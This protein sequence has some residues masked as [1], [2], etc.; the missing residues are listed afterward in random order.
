M[1]IQIVIYSSILF[2]LSEFAL[3]IAKRS[4]K[5]GSKTRNDKSSLL[6]LWLAIPL[7]LTAGFFNAN[8]QLWDVY[9]QTIAIVGLSVLVI[10]ISIR[11]ISIIQLNKGFTVDVAITE[12]HKLKTDGMYK[13]I[14]H[15]S[16]F[17]LILI[18]FGLSIAM[19]S[20]ISILAITIPIL[21]A[22]LYR[23][24]VEE[25]I[26]V[27][28]FGEFYEDYKKKTNKIIPKLY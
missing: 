28:E 4:T 13:N 10:G 5:K 3:M 21:L 26:L 1:N 19:N 2:F 17:G 20:V 14:R 27:K 18:C 12:N 9:N 6:L 16:Y 8:Y 15:P 11:W 25:D 23:I 24:K 7:G 22:I